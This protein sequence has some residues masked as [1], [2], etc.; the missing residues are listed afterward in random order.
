MENVIEFLRDSDTAGVTFSQRRYITKIRKLAEKHPDQVRILAE[1]P[2]GSILARI[3]VSWIRVGPP[4]K[5]QG[6][7]MDEAERLIRR[8]RLLRGKIEAQTGLK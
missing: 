1:N 5:S 3:P 4:R 6:P 2:D 8:S 7:P